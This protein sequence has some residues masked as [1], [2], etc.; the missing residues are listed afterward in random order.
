[1]KRGALVTFSGFPNAPVCFLP[2]NGLATLAAVIR[3]AGHDVT[4][5][6]YNTLDTM[7]RL[8]PD[9]YAARLEPLKD[10]ILQGINA[11]TVAHL[12]PLQ[13]ELDEFHEARFRDIGRELVEFIGARR[14]DWLGLK[15]WNGDGY[16]A[17]R[18]IAETVKAAMPDLPILAGGPHVDYFMEYILE[19]TPSFDFVS[20]AEG[21]PTLPAFLQYLEGRLSLDEVPNLIYRR[22]GKSVRTF[23]KRVL[24]LD[25]I[26]SPN[27]D[28]D[29][30]PAL[31]VPDQKA[32]I[33]VY[34]ESRGCPIRCHF[35][36]HP[37]KS[38][39]L[40]RKRSIE[41]FIADI[42]AQKETY[43][44]SAF[45]FSGSYTP[46]KYLQEICRALIAAK[47][48]IDFVTYGHIGDSRSVDFELIRKGGCHALFFGVESGS[49]LILRDKI[50]KRHSLDQSV[51]VLNRAKAAGIFTIASVIYPNLGETD[52]TRQATLELLKTVRPDSVP[53]LWPALIPNTNWSRDPERF[54]FSIP[55]YDAY[56][57]AFLTYRIRLMLP[58]RFSSVLPYRIGDQE[59]PEFTGQSERFLQE[60]EGLGILTLVGDD[61]ALVAHVGGYSARELRDI[62]R[63]CVLFGTA[64]PVEAMIRRVNAGVGTRAARRTA[65]PRP[66]AEHSPAATL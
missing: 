37:V 25:D 66:L 28:E 8:I 15:I 50:N 52:E 46:S 10:L 30:Y 26:P 59:F 41:R 38:G 57:E 7:K 17:S 56:L 6:D 61:A 29:V 39:H 55:D 14:L 24:D 54:G 65:A 16:R 34:E 40:F 4:I 49:E 53:S 22:D 5:L 42:R 62:Y 43:G 9:W 36:A 60:L 18:I 11:E 31:Y 23:E 19:K 27:Y 63:R 3:R 58:P 33:A 32:R 47:L 44:F 20:Y 45:K 2:D 48:E 1:M 21:E 64:E 13:D 51:S 12:K 35:C